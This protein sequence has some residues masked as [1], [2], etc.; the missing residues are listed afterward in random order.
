MWFRICE[1]G[2][3]LFGAGKR[4]TFGGERIL[5]SA[6]SALQ[7][8]TLF[9]SF[10]GGGIWVGMERGNGVQ[11]YQL[12][13]NRSFIISIK[14]C[15][16]L[17]KGA[18]WSLNIPLRYVIYSILSIQSNYHQRYRCPKTTRLAEFRKNRYSNIYVCCSLRLKIGKL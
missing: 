8:N 15:R 6:L 12:L 11:G 17:L 9:L 7:E 1:A 4:C 18:K 3:N 2:A 5:S 14:F 13:G 10:N 16:I